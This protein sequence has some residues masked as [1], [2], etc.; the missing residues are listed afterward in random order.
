MPHGAWGM[1]PTWIQRI[2][3]AQKNAGGIGHIISDYP[4]Q[5]S[6]LSLIKRK[7]KQEPTASSQHDGANS[8]TSPEN[9]LEIST[10]KKY[11]NM[12]LQCI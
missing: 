12:D 4:K 1:L 7:Q 8:I 2:P 9:S 6:E 5:I 11:H 10:N 3:I